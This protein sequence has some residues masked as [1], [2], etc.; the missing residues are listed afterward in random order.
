MF[1]LAIS[2]V[3][4]ILKKI[5]MPIIFCRIL[6]KLSLNEETKPVL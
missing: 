3:K 4:V 5:P 6:K 2:N 1:K